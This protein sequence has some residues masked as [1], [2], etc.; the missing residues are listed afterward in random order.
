MIKNVFKDCRKINAH[1][2]HILILRRCELVSSDLP[3]KRFLYS[4]WCKIEPH[5]Q[6]GWR[7]GDQICVHQGHYLSHPWCQ[8]VGAPRMSRDP[9]ASGPAPFRIARAETI[10]WS[11]G[12]ARFPGSHLQWIWRAPH[13]LER[14]GDHG[15]RPHLPSQEGW[16]AQPATWVWVLFLVQSWSRPVCKVCTCSL[17]LKASKHQGNSFQ[18]SSAIYLRSLFLIIDRGK[19]KDDAVCIRIYMNTTQS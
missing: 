6:P 9:G 3:S 10:G 13:L 5:V 17:S 18:W 12:T 14:E 1:I 15:V 4:G 8:K 2:L 7:F 16:R 11:S 19:D